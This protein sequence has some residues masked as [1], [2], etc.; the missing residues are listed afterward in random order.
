M[1]TSYLERENTVVQLLRRRKQRVTAIQNLKKLD[2]CYFDPK[3]LEHSYF[4]QEKVDDCYLES[5][6]LVHS[7]LQHE[8]LGL[9]YLE[10]EKTCSQLF[11][12]QKILVHNSLK[13]DKSRSLLF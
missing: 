3:K 10:C 6:I 11:G 8:K 12:A 2:H 13:Q 4:E 9:S 1:G 7:Y 5:E